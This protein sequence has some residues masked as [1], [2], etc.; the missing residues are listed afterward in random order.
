MNADPALKPRVFLGGG[1]VP[2]EAATLP[3]D[4][5]AV[6]YGA[7]VF[8]GI[9]AY[10]GVAGGPS[11]FFRL[12]EHLERLRHSIRIM[13]I[14]GGEDQAEWEEALRETLRGNNI[15]G[16]AH[17]RLSV[18]V[19]GEGGCETRGPALVACSA[20]PRAAQPLEARAGHARVASWRRVEDAVMPPRVKAGAN[21][22]NGRSGLLEARR[23]GYDEALFLTAAGKVSEAANSCFM[24]VRA[25]TLVTP[26]ATAAILESVTRATLLELARDVLGIPTEVRE[27]DRSELYVAEEAFLCGSSHEVKPLLSIDRFALGEG[28]VGKVTRALWSL[29]DRV[30]RGGEPRFA[31][32]LTPV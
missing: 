14:D 27:I 31:H 7:N 3:I 9:C 8:E 32:W 16:D 6:K 2:A 20:T 13:E 21:Y 25:G 5:A 26:P 18:F 17:L 4:S 29:Y 22:H 24:M 1:L 28:G 12:P 23:D 19:V 10:A 11:S 30:V 15:R